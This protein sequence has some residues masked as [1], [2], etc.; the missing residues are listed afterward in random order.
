MAGQKIDSDE[1]VVEKVLEYLQGMAE[2]KAYHLTGVKSRELNDAIAANVKV[3]TDMEMTL[4]P[5][6]SAQNL[7]AK[8]TGVCMVA[9]SCFF[10]C[11]GTMDALTAIVMVISAFIVLCQPRD[12]RQLFRTSQSGGCERDES[13]G[14]PGY[15]ADGYH[16]GNDHPQEQE[17]CRGRCGILL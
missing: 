15:A 14:D 8:L 12:S 17:S 2:V 3:N 6:M 10:Y 11:K 5:R 1:R 16:R 13:A 9:L 4:I 7:I